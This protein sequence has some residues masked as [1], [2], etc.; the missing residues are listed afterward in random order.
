MPAD[1]GPG[2]SLAAVVRAAFRLRRVKLAWAI[3]LPTQVQA[4]AWRRWFG[5]PGP[6]QSPFF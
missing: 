1:T 6:W 4:T 2:D 3:C 5:Q